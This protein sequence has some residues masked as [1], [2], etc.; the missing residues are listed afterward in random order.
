M[1]VNAGRRYRLHL[2][3]NS[4][5]TVDP[6]RELFSGETLMSRFAMALAQRKALDRKELN[7]LQREHKSLMQHNYR[8]QD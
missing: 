1:A 8:L 7:K 3:S 2:L 6:T 4:S 5:A